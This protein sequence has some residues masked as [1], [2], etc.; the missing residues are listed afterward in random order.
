ME[1]SPS[2][3]LNIHPPNQEIARLL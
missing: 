1:Q 2:W 3:E